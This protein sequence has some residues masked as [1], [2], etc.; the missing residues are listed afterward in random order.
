[1]DPREVPVSEI[2]Q[3]D[4]VHMSPD[5]DLDYVSELVQLG[6][7]RHF[8]VLDEG[9]LVGIVS[10]RDLLKA[11]L[12]KA[13]PVAEERR[14]EFLRTVRVGE[15]MAT[16]VHTVAPD[17]PLSDV[18]RLLDRYKIGCVV[19]VEGDKAVGIATETDLLRR[20]YIGDRPAGS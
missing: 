4:F 14:R 11:S 1:M 17:T 19:V 8:A 13:L 2:M 10:Q 15:V 20:A 3:A 7:V 9:R 18:A 6:R 12:T 5:D 16:D